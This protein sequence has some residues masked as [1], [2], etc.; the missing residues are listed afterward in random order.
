MKFYNREKELELMERLN[1]KKPSFLVVTGRRR[2]GKTELIREFIRQRAALYYFVDSNKSIEVLMRE[3][4]Q[5]TS[6]TLKLPPM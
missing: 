1:S 2:V 6:E 3:F 4:G 5:Y